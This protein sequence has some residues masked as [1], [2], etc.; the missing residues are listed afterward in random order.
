MAVDTGAVQRDRLELETHER[1]A[2]ELFKDSIEPAV[3]RPAMAARGDAVP[4]AEL[5]GSPR[6][7]QVGRQASVPGLGESHPRIVSRGG[8]TSVSRI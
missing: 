1:F 3:P 4:A 7:G 8:P 6:H 5:R 2:L